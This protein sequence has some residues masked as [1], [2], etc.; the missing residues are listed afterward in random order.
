MENKMKKLSQNFILASVRKDLEAI[1]TEEKRE[2]EERFFKEHVNFIGCKVPEVRT[3]AQRHFKALEEDGWTY[4]NFVR[5]SEELLKRQTFEEGVVA[6]Y[7]MERVLSNS[8]K[9]DF[10]NFEIFERWLKS[11]V[12]NWAHCD[13]L[14]PHLIGELV[15]KQPELAVRVFEWTKS[16]NRWVR[17][18][19]AVTYVIHGR[20]GR[21]HEKIFKT[22]EALIADGDEMVQKGVGWMLKCASEA[23]EE[24]VVKFLLK[25]KNR[26]PRLVL[27]YAAEKM[28]AKN[29]KLALS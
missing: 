28:S 24:E 6:F 15:G 10:E 8:E 4:E 7:I 22:A 5:L 19:A 2:A 1:A 14:A 20:K 18:A 17:R 21:F 26:A 29:R 25:W 9:S 27:R 12:G 11:Y 3:V 13:E 16:K 23:D